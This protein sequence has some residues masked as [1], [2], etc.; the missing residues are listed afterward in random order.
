MGARKT[1]LSWPVVRQFTVT[2]PLG[3]L[4]QVRPYLSE[5]R[6]NRDR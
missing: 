3:R 5:G 4:R 6:P 1:F 2:D